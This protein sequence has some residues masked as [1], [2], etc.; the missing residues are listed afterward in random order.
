VIIIENIEIIYDSIKYPS[1]DWLKVIILGVLILLPIIG[2]LY[3]F[4]AISP[5]LLLFGFL[6][7]GYLYRIIKSFIAGSDVLPDFDDWSLMA[8]DG[9]KIAIVATCYNIPL[10][11][12][13]LI[14]AVLQGTVYSFFLPGFTLW[15]FLTGS[16]L[17]L[18]IFVL[19]GLIESIAFANMALYNGEISAAFRFSEI[20]KRISMIGWVK[21]L[22]WYISVLLIGLIAVLIAYLTMMIIIGIVL[23]PLIIIPYSTILITRSLALIFA[24]SES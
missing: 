16:P 12:F 19:I 4:T 14:F 17:Q 8:T 20:L 7:L 2:M 1:T 15:S 24:S 18:I 13:A 23:V 9:F 3:S 11:I 10:I 5:L 22:S 6:P 21:Y